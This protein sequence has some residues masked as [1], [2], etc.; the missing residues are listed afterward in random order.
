MYDLIQYIEELEKRIEK[1]EKVIGILIKLILLDFIEVLLLK[2]E[3][4][5][6]LIMLI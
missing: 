3:L 1:N 2:K 5:I 4:K 6:N